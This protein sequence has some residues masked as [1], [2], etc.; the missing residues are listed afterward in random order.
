MW[1]TRAHRALRRQGPSHLAYYPRVRE[2]HLIEQ[3]SRLPFGS[4]ST[5]TDSNQRSN[6]TVGVRRE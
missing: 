3:D 4:E 1:K 2:S 6:A 5:C